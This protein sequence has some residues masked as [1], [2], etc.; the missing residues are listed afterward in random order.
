MSGLVGIVEIPPTV[1]AVGEYS[2]AALKSGQD[3]T[4]ADAWVEAVAAREGQASRAAAGFLLGG[5]SASRGDS[6]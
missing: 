1:N 5:E 2:I 6:R 4:P 3:R